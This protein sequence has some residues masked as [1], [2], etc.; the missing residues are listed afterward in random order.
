LQRR[1]FKE[2]RLQQFRSLVHTG[3]HGSFTAAA[4][5]L[6][7]SRT[8]VWQQIRALEDDFS[9]E[10]VVM[11]DRQPQLSAEGKLL[12]D[13]LV[14]LVNEFE[15]VKETFLSQL[16]RVTQKLTVATTTSLLNYELSEPIAEFRR[17]YPDV[18]L[19]FIDRT[20]AAATELLSAA[21]ADLAVVGRVKG[22]PDDPSLETRHL[23][24]CP[25]VLARR[26]DHKVAARGKFA[27]AELSKHPLIIPCVGTNG[28]Q[29][30]DAVLEEA[31]LTDKLQIA[32]QSYNTAVMLAY[33][34]QG[35]GVALLSLSRRLMDVY[36][37]R[38]R[39]QDVSHL[40]GHEE[41]IVV[42]RKAR[43]AQ[44]R[45][46]YVDEFVRLI[47]RHNIG[48]KVGA[49]NGRNVPGPNSVARPGQR[50]RRK[51]GPSQY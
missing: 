30:I 3:R 18:S 50:P 14:P 29:R 36:K 17:K 22:L 25:F 28:R 41:V 40:F 42:R 32:M 43:F 24:N 9:V 31:G 10:L 27:I 38:L 49:S 8:S 39:I 45:H 33:A 20:S 46:R 21:K 44:E 13:M 51:N 35:L 7:L 6:G 5:E 34:E 15:A 2:L 1:Y 4:R 12:F 47:F 37:R 16:N 48:A 19:S 26:K 11:M 23:M